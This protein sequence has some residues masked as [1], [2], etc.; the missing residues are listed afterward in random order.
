MW[1]LFKY[2]K[3]AFYVKWNVRPRAGHVS[4]HS[5]M[6]HRGVW[7]LF[8]RSNELSSHAKCP[9]GMHGYLTLDFPIGK[10]QA[11]V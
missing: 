1:G 2:I 5:F 4:Y 8:P 3:C 9:L 7:N 11:L 6:L 10:F